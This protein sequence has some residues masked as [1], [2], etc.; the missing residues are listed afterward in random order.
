MQR[1]FTIFVILAIALCG[2]TVSAFAGIYGP[3]GL[4]MPGSYN[5]FNNPPTLNAFGGIEVVGGTLLIDNTLATSRYRTLIHVAA[6]GDITTGS[7]DFKFSSGPTGSPWSNSWGDGGTIAANTVTHLNIGGG[8]ANNTFTFNDNTYYSVSWI[9]S[10]YAGTSFVMMATS[11]VPVTIPTVAQFPKAAHVGT[12]AVTV[13]V[14]TSAAPA[15]E[16]I[17][18]VRYS[19]DGW[20]T[21]NLALVSFVG[22]NGTA[23]IPGQV[24]GTTVSYYVFSTTV[25][26]PSSN[27]DV[28][29][30]NANTNSNANYTYTTSAHLYVATVTSPWSTETW[31]PAGTPGATDTVVVPDGVTLTV[32]ANETV[33]SIIVGNGTSG[34]LN[35]DDVAATLRKLTLSNDITINSGGQFLARITNSGWDTLYFGGNLTNNGTFNLA[36]ETFTN[37]STPRVVWQLCSQAK[38]VIN[39]YTDR[40]R[41]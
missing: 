8:T 13:N 18:Y 38:R 28:V 4:N 19:T 17:V 15:P 39:T 22:A 26:S 30:L 33:A 36:R 35:F 20:V 24:A 27:Y 23:S 12:G 34:I 16:E 10:G 11:A 14:T 6:A 31:N 1:F 2:M 41:H 21:S 32:N 9:D 7:Y 40:L 37:G 3:E 5:G 25:G 29:T